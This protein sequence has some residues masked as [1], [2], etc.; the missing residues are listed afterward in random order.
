MQRGSGGG[1][2][3]PKHLTGGHPI[4]EEKLRNVV[5]LYLNRIRCIIHDLSVFT[6]N[7]LSHN[8]FQY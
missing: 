5:D 4:R 1:V 2:G 8:I 6:N 7:Y 3:G